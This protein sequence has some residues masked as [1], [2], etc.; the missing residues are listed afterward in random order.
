MNGRDV[1]VL[2]VQLLF[3]QNI[4]NVQTHL[5]TSERFTESEVEIDAKAQIV[6]ESR[7]QTPELRDTTSYLYRH[8]TESKRGS[9][10]G[11]N[12]LLDSSWSPT[13]TN[14]SENK[15]LNYKSSYCRALNLADAILST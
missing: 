14:S 10:T 2:I 5:Q 13:E 8:R 11:G 1:G 12:L 3:M 6:T 9:P 7:V 4:R 15:R